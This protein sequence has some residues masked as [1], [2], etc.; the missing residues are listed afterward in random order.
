MKSRD[1]SPLEFA[2][3]DSDGQVLRADPPVRFQPKLDEETQQLY[4]AEDD[5]LDLHAFATTR[6]ELADEITQHIFFAWE[7]YVSEKPDRMTQAARRLK[8]EY[9]SRFRIECPLD[10]DGFEEILDRQNLLS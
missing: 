8:Q 5:S 7:T 10:R 9:S 2:T 6:E 3:F 1:L 4:V